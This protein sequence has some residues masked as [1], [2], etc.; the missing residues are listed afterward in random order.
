[1]LWIL[2]ILALIIFI[3]VQ[4]YQFAFYGVIALIILAAI[5]V[6]VIL[7]LISKVIWL[8]RKS[9]KEHGKGR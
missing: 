5:I 8:I 3:C 7:L 9:K 6:L 2:G 1:M 4:V